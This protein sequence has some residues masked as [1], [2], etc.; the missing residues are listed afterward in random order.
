LTIELT[1]QGIRITTKKCQDLFIERFQVFMC[2]LNLQVCANEFGKWRSHELYYVFEQECQNRQA[3]NPQG[4]PYSD[5]NPQGLLR[6]SEESL[7]LF[8]LM[9]VIPLPT[10]LSRQGGELVSFAV[11]FIGNFLKA[12]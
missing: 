8:L 4:S 10:T 2:P 11:D 12:Q 3:N 7:G 5:S 1:E 6:E 9:G